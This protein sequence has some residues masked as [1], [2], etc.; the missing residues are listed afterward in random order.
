MKCNGMLCGVWIANL[1][2]ALYVIDECWC[3]VLKIKRSVGEN[4]EGKNAFV[5]D[6]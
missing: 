2:I 5:S 4:E 1:V 6:M 3:I